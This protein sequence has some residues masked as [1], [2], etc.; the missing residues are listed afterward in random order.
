MPRPGS[1]FSHGSWTRSGGI[2]TLREAD[3]VA[4][5]H[6]RRAPEGEEQ[7]GGDAR[8]R[9]AD[10]GR[11]ARLVV[12]AEHPVGPA[13]ARQRLLVFLDQHGDLARVPGGL[14][15]LEVERQVR[16][17]QIGAVIGDEPL[18]RQV[19]LADQHPVVVFLEHAPHA[20]DDVVHLGLVGRMDLQKALD[21]GPAELIAGIGRV[22]AELGVLHQVP[23]DVDAEAVDAAVEPE[24]QRRRAWPART[25]G[26]RQLRSGCSSRKAW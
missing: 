25:S 21:L 20:G 4:V 6:R 26:L 2:S 17:R 22:V 24:A 1:F 19:D 5:I 12:V 13:A 7:H 8:L 18:D 3:L 9:F 16:A 23:D 11:D 14:D 10:P 15:E